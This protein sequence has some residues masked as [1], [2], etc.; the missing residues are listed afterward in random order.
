MSGERKP[1]VAAAQAKVVMIE[2]T[3]SLLAEI[4]VVELT[5]R[6]IE[7][8]AGLDR[9]AITRQF[10]GELELFIATLEELN[11]RSLERSKALP[12]NTSNFVN[13]ELKMRVNLLAFLILSGVDP[14]R[15]KQMQPSPEVVQEFM[16]RFGMDSE[17]PLLVREAILA[18]LQAIILSRTFFGP[19]STRN[20]PE[21]GIAIFKMVQ[22]LASNPP[23]LVALLGLDEG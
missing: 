12:E 18:L 5:T 14:E 15:L 8:R 4:P 13:E 17:T 9:R 19:T 7:E 21:N 10:G 6:K 3:I 22:Y 2:A 1:R 23:E 16:Q 20:T 11:R